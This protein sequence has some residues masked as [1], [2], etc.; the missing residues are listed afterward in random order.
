[1]ALLFVFFLV[2]EEQAMDIG[3]GQGALAELLASRFKH[4]HGTDLDEGM[5][6]AASRQT[7]HLPN[8]TIS[9]D[10]LEEIKPG[11]GLIT[12]VAVLHHLDAARALSQVRMLFAPG[13]RFLAV[14]LAPG[15]V[16]RPFFGRVPPGGRHL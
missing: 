13:G 16:V 1:M 3:C 14:G 12:M 7:A 2:T 5:R 11:V 15:V 4:V 10:D 8:V 6:M 9:A